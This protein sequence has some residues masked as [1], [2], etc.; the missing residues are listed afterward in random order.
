MKLTKQQRHMAYMIMLAEGRSLKWFCPIAET[1]FGIDLDNDNR[2]GNFKEMLPEL[3]A[4]KKYEDD[5]AF[6]FA[7]SSERISLLRKCITETEDA[8][9]K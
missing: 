3:Y 8:W 4:K 5:G 7:G 2:F 9:P 6:L 1:C